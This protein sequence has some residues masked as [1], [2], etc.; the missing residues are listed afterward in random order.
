MSKSA[1]IRDKLER[2]DAHFAAPEDVVADGSLSHQEKTDVLDILE[3][4]ARLLADATSEGMRGG[5]VNKLH[6]G[7][8]AKNA[9]AQK[10]KAKPD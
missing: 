3:Q 5:E 10:P 6:E 1:K 9:L 7:L 8:R 2:P 4:D